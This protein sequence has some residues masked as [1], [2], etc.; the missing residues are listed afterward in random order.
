[1]FL[2]ILEKG[3]KSRDL[4]LPH[5]ALALMVTYMPVDMHTELPMFCFHRGNLKDKFYSALCPFL[6]LTSVLPVSVGRKVQAC[7]SL[8]SSFGSNDHAGVHVSPNKWNPSIHPQ[9]TQCYHHTEKGSHWGSS[10]EIKPRT[11]GD[12]QSHILGSLTFPQIPLKSSFFFS[13]SKNTYSVPGTV[14]GA[15]IIM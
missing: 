2:N 15:R 5:P 6:A 8:C 10:R 12:I 9:E 3:V 4:L 11:Y 1:M 13:S 7:G 14:E